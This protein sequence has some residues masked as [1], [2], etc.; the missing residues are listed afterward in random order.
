MTTNSEPSKP[1]KKK[2]P[3][4]KPVFILNSRLRKKKTK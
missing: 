2:I 4:R 1:K 3:I